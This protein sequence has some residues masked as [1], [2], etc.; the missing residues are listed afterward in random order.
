[1]EGVTRRRSGWNQA[2]TLF[3]LI[4]VPITCFH[5]FMVRDA[6]GFQQPAF[7]RIFFW[8]FPCPIIATVLLSQATFFAWKYLKTRE[9]EWDV[10]A[11]SLTELAMFFIVLTMITGVFFS[12]I[13]WGAWWQNDPR[14]VSFLLVTAIYSG[15][16][17]LRS[18]FD[19]DDQK[20]RFS[21]AFHLFAILPFFFLTFVYPRLP[22]IET[23]HPNQTVMTGQLKGGYRV[24]ILETMLVMSL[25]TYLIY[26]LKTKAGL[27]AQQ[28]K[29]YGTT[30][31]LENSGGD[32]TSTH[33]VRPI[34][35]S[36]ES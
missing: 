10:R 11:H 36:D 23:Y 12:R 6:V 20:G 35:L 8:H 5:S 31:S 34:S 16:F 26:Q 22:Q 25:A 30:R 21:N 33:M 18:A 13:Q 24:V 32:S 7:A 27:L 9:I 14:Q 2:I 3:L 1:M 4:A 17:V 15:Y 28:L 19:D 29:N